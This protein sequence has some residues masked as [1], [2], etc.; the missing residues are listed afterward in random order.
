MFSFLRSESKTKSGNRNSSSSSLSSVYQKLSGGSIQN[1]EFNDDLY[2]KALSGEWDI[3][4]NQAVSRKLSTS[5]ASVT[6]E[7]PEQITIAEFEQF[8]QLYISSFYNQTA[9]TAGDNALSLSGHP[10]FVIVQICRL[11]LECINVNGNGHNTNSPKKGEKLLN[12]WDWLIRNANGKVAPSPNMVN[13]VAV[14]FMTASSSGSDSRANSLFCLIC[15]CLACAAYYPHNCSIIASS[16]GE[17]FP[18]LV[19]CVIK[20][21]LGRLEDSIQDLVDFDSSGGGDVTSFDGLCSKAS[22][23]YSSLLALVQF[24][25]RCTTHAQQYQH[26]SAHS[27]EFMYRNHNSIFGILAPLPWTPALVADRFLM[28]S[29]FPFPT[30]VQPATANSAVATATAPGGG[31]SPEDPIDLDDV[32]LNSGVG[33]GATKPSTDSGSRPHRSGAES[34]PSN[35]VAVINILL[36]QSFVGFGIVQVILSSMRK[37]MYFSIILSDTVSKYRSSAASVGSTQ[38]ELVDDPHFII[39]NKLHQL[40][41]TGVL[42][43]VE[44]LLCLSNY[45][46]MEL[47]SGGVSHMGVWEQFHVSE[48]PELLHGILG[49][50]DVQHHSVGG[51]RDSLDAGPVGQL[52]KDLLYFRGILCVRIGSVSLTA[53][54]RE[55]N[56]VGT[57]IELQDS[58]HD[59]NSIIKGISRFVQW[60]SQHYFALPCAP[61]SSAS[62][63]ASSMSNSHSLVCVSPNV[64]DSRANKGKQ[65]LP[66][67]SAYRLYHHNQAATDSVLSN[68]HGFFSPV[69]PD[70]PV[71]DADKGKANLRFHGGCKSL[72]DMVFAELD[73]AG[74]AAPALLA[75]PALNDLWF[76]SNSQVA[77]SL[78]GYQCLHLFDV[79]FQLCKAVYCCLKVAKPVSGGSGGKKPVRTLQQQLVTTFTKIVE[80]VLSALETSYNPSYISSVG[81]TA[82]QSHRAKPATSPMASGAVGQDENATAVPIVFPMLQAHLIL[83]LYRCLQTYP[84]VFVF[85]SRQTQLAHVLTTSKYFWKVGMENKRWAASAN[86]S[87]GFS[88]SHRVEIAQSRDDIVQIMRFSP[89]PPVEVI[90]GAASGVTDSEVAM[91]HVSLRDFVLDYLMRVV[92]ISVSLSRKA[93]TESTHSANSATDHLADAEID[94]V[95]I[96]LAQSAKMDDV[97]VQT[98]RWLYTV[99]KMFYDGDGSQ[100]KSPSSS[101]RSGSGPTVDLKTY[102]MVDKSRKLEPYG[103][104]GNVLSKV[105]SVCRIISPPNIIHASATKPGGNASGVLPTAKE[106]NALFA[107]LQSSD[108]TPTAARAGNLLRKIENQ[109]AYLW[110]ARA[111]VIT[112]MQYLISLDS[113]PGWS[114]GFQTHNPITAPSQPGNR[115]RGASVFDES[116]ASSASSHSA[117]SGLSV[118]GDVSPQSGTMYGA[119]RHNRTLTGLSSGSGGSSGKPKDSIGPSSASKPRDPKHMVLFFLLQEDRCRDATVTIITEIFKKCVIEWASHSGVVNLAS[120]SYHVM[121]P[122]HVR[123]NSYQTLA[124]DLLKG[125]I[126]QLTYPNS[127]PVEHCCSTVYDVARYSIFAAYRCMNVIV[128]GHQLHGYSALGDVSSLNE[129]ELDE[130]HENVN[131]SQMFINSI[132][133]V[134]APAS[135][136]GSG[137][138]SS[139]SSSSA[140][141]KSNIYQDLIR[142]LEEFMKYAASHSMASTASGTLQPTGTSPSNHSHFVVNR[143]L[144]PAMKA[145]ILWMWMRMLYSLISD[146]LE[147]R[148]LFARAISMRYRAGSSSAENQL[149]SSVNMP[150]G[151][152]YSYVALV[153]TFLCAEPG[154]SFFT[155]VML[156]DILLD[157]RVTHYCNSSK[158]NAPASA[159]GDDA[160]VG[161]SSVPA[162]VQ[163]FGIF[164]QDEVLCAMLSPTILNVSILPVIICL[165]PHCEY[166]LQICICK[167]LLNLLTG[168]ARMINLSKCSQMMH[169]PT[170]TLLDLLIDIFPLITDPTL[171]DLLIKLMQSV[172]KHSITVAQ[173]KRI[174]IL[175]QSPTSIANCATGAPGA[176]TTVEYRSA[177]ARSL[178]EALSGMLEAP[179]NATGG[180]SGNGR[181]RSG[182]GGLLT[183]AI[184]PSQQGGNRQLPLPPKCFFLF[185]GNESG[186]R[187]PSFSHWPATKGYTFCMWFCLSSSSTS[188]SISSSPSVPSS[189]QMKT[190][191]A[192]AVPPMYSGMSMDH[193]AFLSSAVGSDAEAGWL[194]V[195]PDSEDVEI[196]SPGTMR[197]S[198]RGTMRESMLRS[199]SQS[200][201]SGQSVPSAAR[202]VYRP[203]VFSFKEMSGLGMDV[204]FRQDEECCTDYHLVIRTFNGKV[205][206]PSMV[207]VG[208]SKGSEKG[209][210]NQS[211]ASKGIITEG[212]WHFLAISHVSSGFRTK[213]EVAVQIDDKYFAKRALS[214]PRYSG[215]VVDPTIGNC[216]PHDVESSD[217][218]L[219]T[220]FHGQIS[221]IYLFSDALS[222]AQLQGINNLGPE[223]SQM[224]NNRDAVSNA[225][226]HHPHTHTLQQSV[227]YDNTPGLL[228]H[229]PA[230]D[231][232]LTSHIIL[233][234]NPAIWKTDYCID[235]TPDRNNI[236]WKVVD[237]NAANQSMQGRTS[238]GLLWRS[239]RDQFTPGVSDN[240][241]ALRLPGTY[242]CATK[243]IRVAL[244]CLGGIKVLLPLFAQFDLPICKPVVGGSAEADQIAPSLDYSVDDTLCV[245]VLELVFSMLKESPQNNLLMQSTGFALLSY[246]LE[247]I[248]PKYLSIAALRTIIKLSDT[249]WWNESWQNSVYE[250]VLCNFKLWMYTPY[251]VQKILMEYLWEFYQEHAVR[252][253][254]MMSVQ[255]LLDVLLLKYAAV[256][257]E[258]D[259]EQVISSEPTWTDSGAGS[260]TMRSRGGS[261]STARDAPATGVTSSSS[262]SDMA[263]HGQGSS[264]AHSRRPSLGGHNNKRRPA[265][266]SSTSAIGGTG[267]AS[268][269]SI[270]P[271]R[272][273][274]HVTRDAVGRRL[275]GYELLEIRNILWQIVYAMLASRK[276][277]ASVADI[278]ALLLHIVLEKSESHKIQ[279]LKILLRLMNAEDERMCKLVLDAFSTNMS[280]ASVSH[281]MAAGAVG[282]ASLPASV[283]HVACVNI[284]LSLIGYS[285]ARVR[286]YALLSVCS[287]L[288]IAA[289]YGVL[290]AVNPA[291]TAAASGTAADGM[292]VEAEGDSMGSAGHSG[293]T[294]SIYMPGVSPVTSAQ[295]TPESTFMFGR[296]ASA[297]SIFEDIGLPL[298]NLTAI[299]QWIVSTLLTHIS[300]DSVHLST[301]KQQ[302][303]LVFIILHLTM[304][305]SSC[306]ELAPELDYIV[307]AHTKTAGTGVSDVQVKSCRSLASLAVMGDSISNLNHYSNRD[308]VH[309][310]ASEF[311]YESRDALSTAVISIPMIFPGLISITKHDVVTT[312][313][314]QELFVYLKVSMQ[315]ATNSDV[316]LLLPSWQYYIFDFLASEQRRYVQIEDRIVSGTNS[317]S[318]H[319]QDNHDLNTSK[320]IIETGVRMLCDIQIH[321]IKSCAPVGSS[322]VCRPGD[323]LVDTDM[324]QLS[325]KEIGESL[326]RGRRV[327]AAVLKETMS[328]LRCFAA[329]GS[330]DMQSTG[331]RLL[332]R[333]I[334]A[335]QR[336]SESLDNGE[337]EAAE[338]KQLRRRLLNLNLWLTAAVLLEFIT[339]PALQPSTGTGDVKQYT[340]S[341]TAEILPIN[342]AL[343]KVSFGVAKRGQQ[344]SPGGGGNAE[345]S[346]GTGD[347]QGEVGEPIIR[348]SMTGYARH[349]T[350]DVSAAVKSLANQSSDR[351][352]DD[353]F[354]IGRSIDGGKPGSFADT[355]REVEEGALGGHLVYN[356]SKDSLRSGEKS[357]GSLADELAINEDPRDRSQSEASDATPDRGGD[358]EMD[359]DDREVETPNEYMDIVWN[360][361]DSI[362]ELLNLDSHNSLVEKYT[363][364]TRS[365]MQIG[366]RKGYGMRNAVNTTID[367]IVTQASAHGSTLSS[368]ADKTLLRRTMIGNSSVTS[369]PISAK[370]SSNPFERAIEGVLW[371]IMRVLINMITNA[372]AQDASSST[373]GDGAPRCTVGGNYLRAAEHL[374][375]VINSPDG[376]AQ[377]YMSFEVMNVICRL[378]TALYNSPQTME[379]DWTQNVF[380]LLMKLIYSQRLNIMARFHMVA[381]SSYAAPQHPAATKTHS[382]SATGSASSSTIAHLQEFV[383][384][385]CPLNSVNMRKQTLLTV[386]QMAVAVEEWQVKALQ[387]CSSASAPVNDAPARPTTP[388][389]TPMRAVSE[390]QLS[391]KVGLAVHR[392]ILLEAI[393]GT[394]QFC[395]SSDG[396]GST[397]SDKPRR[398]TWAMWH[399]VMNGVAIDA[400]KMED[401]QLSSKLTDM[402]LHRH[403]QEVQ[404]TID[405][406]CSTESRVFNNLRQDEAVGVISAAECRRI[407]DYDRCVDVV[408]RRE[409]EKKWK[410]VL[411]EL[412]NER[413]P[414]GKGVT[415]E[416]TGE[417]FWVVNA[418][419]DNWRKRT[420]IV[421]NPK[422]TRHKTATLL[423]NPVY[424]DGNSGSGSGSGSRSRS[425][426]GTAAAVI[427]TALSAGN[428]SVVQKE[429]DRNLSGDGTPSS[430]SGE[431][432]LL[433]ASDAGA[434]TST[435]SPPPG[436]SIDD[437][438]AGEGLLSAM[439][440]PGGTYGNTAVSTDAIL[441]Y[442]G[443]IR[444][445]SHYQNDP[446]ANSKSKFDGKASA[447]VIGGADDFDGEE[448]DD[449]ESLLYDS[450]GEHVPADNVEDSAPVMAAATDHP[451]SGTAVS[452]FSNDKV[453][454]SCN[455]EVILPSTNSMNRPSYG[456]LELTKQKLSFTKSTKARD[457]KLPET[458]RWAENVNSEHLWVCQPFPSTTWNCNDI[459]DILGRFYQLRFV[460][461]EIFFTNRTSLLFNLIDQASSRKICNV[462]RLHVK[463]Y[464][465]RPFFGRFPSEIVSNMTL[466]GSGS[467]L[468]EAWAA[469]EISNFEYLMHLNKIAGRT[470][471]DLGQ[472]PIFPWVLADYKSNSLDLRNPKNFRDFRWPMGAQNEDQRALITQ[473]YNDLRSVY[474]PPDMDMDDDNGSRYCPSVPPFHFG[475]HYS[476]GG[477]VLWY[478]MRMEPYTS[479]HVALQDGKFDKA[480]RL[481][482]S[483]EAAYQSCTTNSSD[484]KELVPE[485]FYC[486]E[487]FDNVNNIDFGTTQANK[488]LGAIALPPWAKDSYDFVHQHR[489]ALESEYVS[490]NMHHWVDLIF[491]YKQ[492]PPHIEGGSEEAVKAC[493]VY[494]HLTY[495]GAVKLDELSPELYEQYVTQIAEFGQTPC[496]LFEQPHVQRQP[497]GDLAIV[498]PI[499]SVLL[500]VDTLSKSAKAPLMPTELICYCAHRVSCA[501]I[502][503]I[504]EVNNRLVTVDLQRIIGYHHWTVLSPDIVPPF[505]F[506][507]DTAALE[508]SKK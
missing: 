362:L 312:E 418:C 372:G 422:G 319:E 241:N 176:A 181:T 35:T 43:T 345:S 421:R 7:K 26:H 461:V 308:S 373:G 179:I 25:Y 218:R 115:Q 242:M 445:L 49:M 287:L 453:L 304:H 95:L 117:L 80:G 51:S 2:G 333:T 257:M 8:G 169:P 220:S 261:L 426:T 57:T 317:V 489:K 316:I 500:G 314:R 301:R 55:S 295:K 41:H 442:S 436:V 112:L 107:D 48:G 70:R 141:H 306:L 124:H 139:S 364:L 199:S 24:S 352:D 387:A 65:G 363:T 198:I 232:S 66:A 183:N 36:E 492:R 351:D 499:A 140:T 32:S 360:L 180:A 122:N 209:G 413:G 355:S 238:R 477:F 494:F 223:Y 386:E 395:Y 493:N 97:I 216:N 86:S 37:L 58:V 429:L 339:V 161:G 410:S 13:E 78:L 189:P 357:V 17:L 28:T 431:N 6:G 244:N 4:F 116:V 253:S 262:M 487:I 468:T 467:K 404:G 127:I 92:Q 188:A 482:D 131:L 71:V 44:M 91:T 15:H 252:F 33:V 40:W 284:L 341:V 474:E 102:F 72:L 203:T 264:S 398:F 331:L 120:D 358:F 249:L 486:P 166:T 31:D 88:Y 76:I 475:S 214:F 267:G 392:K 159:S 327:G 146:N 30:D 222:Q 353:G 167:T 248:S 9:A 14:N 504:S 271:E 85:V 459:V 213:S 471:N 303:K 434:P 415:G 142:A 323:S 416:H 177:H 156:F 291:P 194:P 178:V 465:M 394:L 311:I 282:S 318:Q 99:A 34:S 508:F 134:T 234:Y 315:T 375:A 11:F 123:A 155:I 182:S 224:F 100:I 79:V 250:R 39:G 133:A 272:I 104:W 427:A 432:A 265:P 187:L 103:A 74:A 227:P 45:F 496:Q 82:S 56:A 417:V 273:I 168:R 5:T 196:S 443:L 3:L 367:S 464:Y 279:G 89:V 130:S 246:V 488:D 379:T 29:L 158:W 402:G 245:K 469:R 290:P 381:E 184:Y 507:P 132:P 437:T 268:Y 472:Y 60:F 229:N 10:T 490:L 69:S 309:S 439:M 200:L 101:N 354:V 16:L 251:S 68:V 277:P 260:G 126:N 157:G 90:P 77:N 495:S 21:V 356:G 501:P 81:S 370:L 454:F 105:L 278:H 255:Q 497:L 382:R 197:E 298:S 204:Y 505:K 243:D 389:A 391:K 185:E 136:G 368:P 440:S 447:G 145:D 428:S 479:L 383:S 247:R 129:A 414:W 438:E 143:Y 324:S 20:S 163:E 294:G 405:A 212:E 47:L 121:A 230:L 476:V 452:M 147:G 219:D 377:E 106:A 400:K 172:G 225:S 275:V 378:S 506:K 463:P 144:N 409:V 458:L 457:S 150:G 113:L 153:N 420:K 170:L 302:L 217:L 456:L 376:H 361:I 330:L 94:A 54:R 75:N 336:E 73:T 450:N 46:H 171:Q 208:A 239:S 280:S 125:L 385:L 173:L 186:L 322:T 344:D 135:G 221:S 254:S 335:L 446:N 374:E 27:T 109:R 148:E 365:V 1:I 296:S 425:S 152:I 338:S 485:L 154:S 12:G 411:E 235:N 190:D 348:P 503:L 215:V 366:L 502:L 347:S 118:Q 498:W 269:Y 52:E 270:L 228:S 83:F 288:Q 307:P 349:S 403:A 162:I 87:G 23:N 390:G 444:D 98:A 332:Q 337:S 334:A 201:F 483:L 326:F 430:P 283:S 281:R 401:Q 340:T 61:S 424:A 192:E 412:A 202:K 292:G 266:V 128:P 210:H 350:E 256:G 435:Y 297:H 110:P 119:T 165:I 111:A 193:Q 313:Q 388:T 18:L 237:T 299:V 151:Y 423:S 259:V 108:A 359:D 491:G 320:G 149:N 343:K 441:Q 191:V 274:H 305:G 258:V 286:L 240:M 233:A 321:G 325:T 231:G 393:E 462:V 62:Q 310:M 236:R 289:T 59:V 276:R 84:T 481:F 328:Y 206:Y 478:L 138:A 53:A 300:E 448:F 263:N 207:E 346:S 433:S 164:G 455:C 480:D 174:F 114:Q 371:V 226:V 419:E 42:L 473:K 408:I 50:T 399:S 466:V 460:A 329:A 285:K 470:Y 211:K 96:L 397:L 451:H 396:E 67:C 175:M 406:L 407:K 22:C 384:Q 19:I 38:S 449:D 369:A 293:H 160:T 205:E 63:A 195:A 137:S 342:K 93:P 484:I 380:M 64:L